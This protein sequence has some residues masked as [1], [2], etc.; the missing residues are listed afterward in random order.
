ML[1]PSVFVLAKCL[2]KTGSYV[3]GDL[4]SRI[5]VQKRIYLLQALGLDLKYGFDWDLYGPYS[6][7]LAKDAA[8]YNELMSEVD[9]RVKDI[10]ITAKASSVFEKANELMALPNNYDQLTSWLELLASI[11]FLSESR[12]AGDLTAAGELLRRKPKFQDQQEIINAAE[13]RLQAVGLL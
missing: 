4:E 1:T 10:K 9:S 2:E 12:T 13:E 5:C 7:D 6:S 8:C 3:P 11:H